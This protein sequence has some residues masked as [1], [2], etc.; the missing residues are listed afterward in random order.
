[1]MRIEKEEP[2]ELDYSNAPTPEYTVE[3][4]VKMITL[5]NLGIEGGNEAVFQEIINQ[6]A[7]K[8]HEVENKYIFF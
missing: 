7:M 8:V 5:K 6:V 3:D 1:M 2:K 4:L